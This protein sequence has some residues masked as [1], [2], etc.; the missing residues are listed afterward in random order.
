MSRSRHFD[1]DDDDDDDDFFFIKL[2]PNI[3]GP[4]E[5]FGAVFPSPTLEPHGAMV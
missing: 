1:D 3:E 5:H 2:S 4:C